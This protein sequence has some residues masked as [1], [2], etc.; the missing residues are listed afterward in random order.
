MSEKLQELLDQLEMGLLDNSECYNLL[1]RVTIDNNLPSSDLGNACTMYDNI[2]SRN[3]W[4]QL[5][6]AVKDSSVS[7]LSIINWKESKM[8][9][10]VFKGDFV[11]AFDTCNR[12]DNFSREGREA[13]FDYLEELDVGSDTESELDPIGVC[14]EFVEYE[15]LKDFQADYSDDY[16]SIDDIQDATHVIRLSGESFII[17]AF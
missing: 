13:L 6:G 15:S 12:S 5:F 7:S 10:T 9:Q 1:W 17:Q 11:R 8:K 4:E 2:I 3:P 16:K 14:C